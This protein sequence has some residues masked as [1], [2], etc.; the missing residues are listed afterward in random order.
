[1]SKMVIAAIFEEEAAAEF[2]EIEGVIDS[3]VF[4]P[5]VNRCVRHRSQSRLPEDPVT[6][7]MR[8]KPRDLTPRRGWTW[9]VLASKRSVGHSSMRT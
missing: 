7:Q 6:I 3:F 1:M 8:G 4:P 2:G 9:N 5:E